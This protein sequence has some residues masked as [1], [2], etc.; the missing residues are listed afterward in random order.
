MSTLAMKGKVVI[1]TGATSGIGRATA[2]GLA[3]MGAKLILVGRNEERLRSTYED[4][5]RSTGNADLQTMS[6]DL[7]S[8][9][10]VRRL[11]ALLVSTHPHLDVL[12][13]NAGTI[14]GRRELTADGYERTFALDHLSP[15][16]LTNLLLTSLKATAPSRIITVSSSAHT[17]GSI[18]FNDLMLERGYN[19][20]KAYGQAKLANIM[21]TYELARRLEG[22]GVTANCVH[23]GAV[24]T[25]FGN[26]ATGLLHIGLVVVR[27]FELSPNR[28]A[29][30]PIYLASSPEVANL[31]G[32]YFVRRRP[33]S[34][35]PASY[36]HEAA[37]RLWEM[38][39][40][41]TGL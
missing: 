2:E 20:F 9:A 10:E 39:A 34:S 35:S 16:L 15:F 26:E 41:L 33:R 19:A 32:K 36:D 13:N 22:T 30:T 37:R 11:A 5:Y 8:M 24:R 18:H 40:K 38:S 7:S 4:I 3:S 17:T 31:S 28:G 21:F 6:A 23:P 1:V 29:Q 12:I 27:P 25:H 14:I